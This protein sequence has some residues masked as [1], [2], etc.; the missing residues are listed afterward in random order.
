MVLA[1]EY[2][3]ASETLLNIVAKFN[4]VFTF[5]F[6]FEILAKMISTGP[7][8]CLKKPV[9][10][11]DFIVVVI[12]VYDFVSMIFNPDSQD[13]GLTV[14]RSLRLLRVFRLAQKWE[15]MKR[16]LSIIFDSVSAV[17]YLVVVLFVVL[18]IFAVVAKS[19]FSTP[20]KKFTEEYHN[21]T[22][23]LN[24][25]APNTA[26]RW[27]FNNFVQSFLLVFRVLCGEWVEPL[28]SAFK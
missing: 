12:G 11:F 2:E 6:L 26:P 3:G 7:I 4:D 15:T 23:N 5:V 27:N 17:A 28:Y 8:E 13:S 21:N 22:D 18:F 20:Y 1:L 16:L 24:D 14:I 9:N 25:I 10:F 19:L